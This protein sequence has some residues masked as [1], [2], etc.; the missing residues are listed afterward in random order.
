MYRV[1]LPQKFAQ[2]IS[3]V[4]FFRIVVCVQGKLKG[5]CLYILNITLCNT[6]QSI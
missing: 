1:H 5:M 6:I 2:A 3:A 4:F